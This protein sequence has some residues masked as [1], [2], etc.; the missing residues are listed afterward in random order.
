[1]RKAIKGG[2]IGGGIVVAAAGLMASTIAAGEA[3]GIYG[4]GGVLGT[5]LFI[6][7]TASGVCGGLDEEILDRNRKN[8]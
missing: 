3:W 6:A 2:L 8:P 7:L 1:M 5:A 4:V